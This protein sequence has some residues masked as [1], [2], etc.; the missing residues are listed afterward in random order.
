MMK[1]L[2]AIERLATM[3]EECTIYA[4]VPWGR[5]SDAVVAMEPENG[6]LPESAKILGLEYFLEVSV[7][8]DVASDF[9]LELGVEPSAE[10]LCDRLIGYAVNDA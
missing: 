4:S 2:E 9:A 3:D 5:N 6:G 10:E 1:L 7:A 8:N